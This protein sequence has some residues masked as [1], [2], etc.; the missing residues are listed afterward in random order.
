LFVVGPFV[1]PLNIWF[2]IAFYYALV[3]NLIVFS[4]LKAFFCF[5]LALK[6]FFKKKNCKRLCF[7]HENWNFQCMHQYSSLNNSF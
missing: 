2:N 5:I 7:V 3:N 4:I 1:T 6:I